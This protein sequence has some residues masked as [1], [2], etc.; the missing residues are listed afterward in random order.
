MSASTPISP[1]PVDLVK[2]K[3]PRAPSLPAKYAKFIHFGYWF[4]NL[5][6]D[7]RPEGTP[8][9]M[10]QDALLQILNIHQSVQLQQAFV[11]N[12]FDNS[13][14]VAKN[15]RSILL[16]QKKNLAKNDKNNNPKPKRLNKINALSQ[17]A[18]VNE[19]VCAANGDD[20]AEPKVEETKE[21]KVKEAKEPK[22]KE[23]KESKVK[24]S[25]VK[26]PKV[27]E[28]KVKEPKVK[29]AKES[30]V[31]EVKEVKEPKVKEA[32]EPKV[33]ETKVK[34]AKEP[35]VKESKTVKEPVVKEDD[36]ETA[37][38]SVLNLNGQQYLIDDDMNVYD[39]A[40]HSLIGKFDS[41]KNVI[42]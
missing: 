9:I 40:N 39:F 30:K 41:N 17:C 12:F 32:K 22:V 25:K 14:D 35:K 4:I 13:K 5:I 24:E 38:V 31:K 7:T 10:E 26:E 23:A 36:E 2:E 29:E 28:S 11:Q 3:K 33:K 15:I 34:E 37:N 16:L 8:P 6:N 19:I 1:V 20:V 42:V 27:K 18:L 21:P